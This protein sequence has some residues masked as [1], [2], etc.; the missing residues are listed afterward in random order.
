[1]TYSDPNLYCKLWTV[2]L[3]FLCHVD[4]NSG[5][6]S[7]SLFCPMSVS[8]IHVA[9]TAVLWGFI[10]VI[11]TRTALLRRFHTQQHHRWRKVDDCLSQFIVQKSYSALIPASSFHQAVQ[12]TSTSNTIKYIRQSAWPLQLHHEGMSADDC[13]W[14]WIILTSYPALITARCFHQAKQKNSR[15]QKPI[16][17]DRQLGKTDDCLWRL[18]TLTSYAALIAARCFHQAKQK[19]SRYQK[20]IST[21]NTI[22]D[23]RQSSSPIRCHYHG[24]SPDA[25]FHRNVRRLCWRSVRHRVSEPADHMRWKWSAPSLPEAWQREKS[26]TMA[27][28]ISNHD[29]G[30]SHGLCSSAHHE[31]LSVAPAWLLRSA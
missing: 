27:A 30:M 28:A 19:N 16:Y 24:W 9:I 11:E 22:R 5:I 7:P 31:Y 29:N 23:G 15:Y 14:R 1:M 18:I 8:H 26:Q 3:L 2:K 20:P 25:K 17:F 21:A 12:N 4:Q 10:N 13:L 6:C